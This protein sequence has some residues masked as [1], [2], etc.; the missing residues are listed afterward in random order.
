MQHFLASFLTNQPKYPLSDAY[1]AFLWTWTRHLG[2]KM[3][4]IS[5]VREKEAKIFRRIVRDPRR[6]VSILGGVYYT[7]SLQDIVRNEMS[8]PRVN[9]LLR[10]MPEDSGEY[11]A[12]LY[13]GQKWKTHPDLRTPMIQHGQRQFF[14]DEF[15]KLDNQE[16]V[17]VRSFFLKDGIIRMRYNRT[18]EGPLHRTYYIVEQP[19]WNGPASRLLR[20]APMVP[21]GEEGSL[22]ARYLIGGITRDGGVV[23]YPLDRL[24]LLC[25]GNPLKQ[26][27]GG[28]PIVR[29][30]LLLFCDDMSGNTSRRYN[31]HESWYFSLA[32]LPFDEQQKEYNTH[33][34][35][36]SN[37]VS[38]MEICAGIAEDLL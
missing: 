3:P 5:S 23:G 9:E 2:V 26:N 17:Y 32:G 31:P 22:A 7:T 24:R 13:Q 4:P 19:I 25:A 28:R 16:I 36:T 8:N 34:L 15:A 10:A 6:R 12:E 33:F 38:G 30:P 29:V 37:A 18:E 35:A 20:P 14:V 21:H 11:L 27:A 1:I